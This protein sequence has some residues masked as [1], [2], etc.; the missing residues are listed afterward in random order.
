MYALFFTFVCSNSGA[1]ILKYD[2]D[3]TEFCGTQPKC[4]FCAF[5]I[6]EQFMITIS[7]RLSVEVS[8]YFYLMCSYHKN[9]YVQNH[10]FKTAAFRQRHISQL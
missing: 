9:K 3:S 4:A 2:P 1:K 7:C 10:L 5:V 8:P 6:Y